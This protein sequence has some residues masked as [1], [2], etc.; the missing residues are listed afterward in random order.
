MERSKKE[1]TDGEEGTG[2][3]ELADFLTAHGADRKKQKGKDKGKD[4]LN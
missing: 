4:I 2:Y 3:L 1:R